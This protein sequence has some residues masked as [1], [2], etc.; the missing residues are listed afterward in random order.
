[1][2]ASQ[3]KDVGSI[4]L[5]RVSSLAR[6]EELAKDWATI[7][8]SLIDPDLKELPNFQANFSMSIVMNDVEVS[9]HAWSPKHDDIA[10]IFQLVQPQDNVLVHCHAGIS[11]STALGLGLWV[12]AGKTI[13]EAVKLV[14]ADRPNM[15]PNKLILQH[16][17]TILNMKGQFVDEVNAAVSKLPRD[18]WLWCND[19]KIHFKDTEKHDCPT[20]GWISETK[21]LVAKS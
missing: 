12:K 9:S 13:D 17:D 5:V 10:G 20:G 16:I 11:R 3:Y 21:I 15:S 4:M 8:V 14:Y 2:P 7:V 1:M 6:A 19:C 18:L